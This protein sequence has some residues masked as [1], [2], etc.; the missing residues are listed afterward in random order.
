M[1]H[2]HLKLA[3]IDDFVSNSNHTSSDDIFAA[4]Q[5]FE[6]TKG[7]QPYR[8]VS[9]SYECESLVSK[10]INGSLMVSSEH[11][12]FAIFD[13]KEFIKNMRPGHWLSFSLED[14]IKHDHKISAVNHTSNSVI[15][16]E[17][18]TPLKIVSDVEYSYF[19]SEW[20]FENS[21]LGVS[22]DC[23]M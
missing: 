9:F 5:G 15:L 11:D 13:D 16:S 6:L 17:T 10:L 21:E 18:V 22:F 7:S 3:K 20:N 8:F 14:G 12:D 23:I 2:T 1:E 4:N 19:F